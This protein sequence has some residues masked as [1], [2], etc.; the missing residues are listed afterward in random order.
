MKL[1]VSE[2][3]FWSHKLPAGAIWQSSERHI[4]FSWRNLMC[5]WSDLNKTNMFQLLNRYQLVITRLC[6]CVCVV[7]VRAYVEMR[8]KTAVERYFLQDCSLTTTC[9]QFSYFSIEC[10]IQQFSEL[11]VV[12]FGNTR[13]LEAEVAKAE[14]P[15]STASSTSTEKKKVVPTVVKGTLLLQTP[16]SGLADTCA[17]SHAVAFI[18]ITLWLRDSVDIQGGPGSWEFAVPW[19]S[20]LIEEVFSF[21]PLLLLSW[22]YMQRPGMNDY[23][24]SWVTKCLREFLSCFHLQVKAK[25]FPFLDSESVSC[26]LVC[27]SRKYISERIRV[28]E[29]YPW[30]V[31][32][33]N[34]SCENKTNFTCRTAS[35]TEKQWRSQEP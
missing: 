4:V 17:K 19:N 6:L 26:D 35:G 16:I 22:R 27:S 15:S 3:W 33:G 12:F 31:C 34:P 23:K 32:V 7:R 20:V 13:L 11:L 2:V 24:F 1:F 9:L 25:I 8:F 28:T 5:P 29:V 18:R 30:L 14:Q 21:L 10:G